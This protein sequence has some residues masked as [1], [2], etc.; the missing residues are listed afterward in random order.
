MNARP[1]VGLGVIIVK[2]GKVLLGKRKGGSGTGTWAFP[3]GHLEY[4]ETFEECAKREVMEEVGIKIKNIQ[5]LTFTNDVDPP[6]YPNHY[7]TLFFKS[8]YDSGD[9]QNCEP[10]KCEGWEWFAWHNLP[11]P[12][13]LSLQ[14]LMKEGIKLFD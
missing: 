10:D 12:L 2:D 8:E 6:S 13:F 5:K 1:K 3:G 9:V 7:I 4:N 14:N 11:Q